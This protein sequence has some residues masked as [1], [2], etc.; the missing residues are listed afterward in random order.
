MP[1]ARRG[2]FEHAAVLDEHRSIRAAVEALRTHTRVPAPT[3]RAQWLAR[4]ARDVEALA[5]LLRPHFVREEEE[6]GLFEVIE[7]ARPESASECARLRAEHGALL[8][9]LATIERK[10][11]VPRH[12]ARSA[13]A[14]SAAIRWLV[15]DLSRHEAAENALLVNAMEGEEVGALD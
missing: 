14:L 5:A 12:T 6:A 13:E 10:L 9:R 1:T 11:G 8:D 2:A 3:G 15:L 7:T 4:L